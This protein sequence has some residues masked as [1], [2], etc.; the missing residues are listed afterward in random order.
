[1][2]ISYSD[3]LRMTPR[4]FFTIVQAHNE[5]MMEESKEK[6]ALT[7]VNA[8]WTAQWMYGKRKPPKLEKLIG[9]LSKPKPMTAAQMLEKVK[10]LNA[11][12]GGEVKQV[13]N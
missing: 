2:G 8:L 5:K 7:Y 6:L 1:M 10:Q 4:D 9:K 11:L 12:F 3:F 13:G